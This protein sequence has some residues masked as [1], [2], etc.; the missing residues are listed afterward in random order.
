LTKTVTFHNLTKTEN[1]PYLTKRIWN[2]F[3]DFDK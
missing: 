1:V 2:S 3:Y